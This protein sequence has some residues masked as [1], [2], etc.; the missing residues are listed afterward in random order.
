[1]HF[2]LELA[3]LLGDA[4]HSRIGATLVMVHHH[5]FNSGIP[6]MDMYRC[7]SIDALCECKRGLDGVL[8]KGQDINAKVFPE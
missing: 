8:L 2:I 3:K 6:Y 5:P 7:E 4:L 1:M